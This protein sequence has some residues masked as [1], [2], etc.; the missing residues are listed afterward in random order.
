MATGYDINACLFLPAAGNRER[1]N[2]EL[3]N[4][5]SGGRYWSGSLSSV[6]SLYLN[7]DG[8]NVY[9][10]NI[11]NRSNGLSVRCIS[12]LNG[13]L[14]LF[15]LVLRREFHGTGTNLFI[16]NMNFDT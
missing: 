7:F 10:A 3:Y 11:T 12:A 16:R 9:P 14:Y 6:Y 15:V 2:G 13:E 8:S 4:V 5:G 1:S